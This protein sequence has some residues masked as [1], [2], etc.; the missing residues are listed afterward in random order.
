MA[1][2]AHKAGTLWT[3]AEAKKQGK[4]VKGAFL[5]I[6]SE[7]KS[8]SKYKDALGDFDH[9]GMYVGPKALTDKDKNGKKRTC[10]VMHSSAT[11]GRVAGSTLAN[12]WTH[13]GWMP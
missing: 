10:D 13:V 7:D 11:M 1:R 6:K 2:A 5:F 3:L 12:G 4:L 8:P 9:V